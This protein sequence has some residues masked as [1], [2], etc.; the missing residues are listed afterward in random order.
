MSDEAQPHAKLLPPSGVPT[1]LDSFGWWWVMN[2]ERVRVVGDTTS[3][4]GYHCANIYEAV[5]VLRQHGYLPEAVTEAVE[6]TEAGL[7]AW[8]YDA[9]RRIMTRCQACD[10]GCCDWDGCPQVR[11]GE[12]EA[13]GRHCPLDT[14]YTVV[15]Q[16]QALPDEA[17]LAVM[18]SFCRHCGGDDPRCQCWNDE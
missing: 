8:R 13:T 18:R 12:P 11:D 14:I 15:E 7:P 2:G 1:V 17:R 4:G 16:M 9:G 5:E 6:I 10:D 3:D